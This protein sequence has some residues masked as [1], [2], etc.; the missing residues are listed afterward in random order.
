MCFVI[1]LKLFVRDLNFCGKLVG[2]YHR[3]VDVKGG[4][5]AFVILL[6]FVVGDSNRGSNESLQFILRNLISNVPLKS[7]HVAKTSSDR[8]FITFQ[9]YKLTRSIGKLLANFF[10]D[11][12]VAR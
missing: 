12:P 9:A 4:V 2:R 7:F 5:L 8:F 11:L 3:V 6:Y 10:R 1:F